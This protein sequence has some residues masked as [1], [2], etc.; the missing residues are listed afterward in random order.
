M[1][2]P[3]FQ[4]SGSSPLPCPPIQDAPDQPHGG[5]C[6]EWIPQ[7]WSQSPVKTPFPAAAS[8][9]ATG[10]KQIWL[11]NT[12]GSPCTPVTI[13]GGIFGRS[14]WW[15]GPDP[16]LHS[17]EG[18]LPTSRE[19]ANLNSGYQKHKTNELCDCLST[20][21]KP[22]GA[23]SLPHL[24][25][26]ATAGRWAAPVPAPDCPTNTHNCPS[27]NRPPLEN[28]HT[29]SIVHRGFKQTKKQ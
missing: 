17:S 13:A 2:Y 8:F 11:G 3:P 26:T 16:T 18:H 10:E 19:K 22:F 9:K 5:A 6:P 23:Q 20:G 24:M 7:S 25:Q 1:F 27:G 21:T 28:T 29:S 4:V 14:S 12:A 15:P